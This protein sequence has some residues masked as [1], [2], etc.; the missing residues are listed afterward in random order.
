[1]SREMKVISFKIP[2]D[3]LKELDQAALEL[4][5]NRSAILRSLVEEFLRKK[6]RQPEPFIGRG[7]KIW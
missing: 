1:M 6:K 7:I 2:V 3:L 4:G 5:T